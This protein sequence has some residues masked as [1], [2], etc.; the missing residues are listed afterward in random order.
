MVALLLASH[1]DFFARGQHLD[2]VLHA[3]C[4]RNACNGSMVAF[5]ASRSRQDSHQ[6]GRDRYRGQEVGM[7]SSPTYRRCH[8]SWLLQTVKARVP[9]MLLLLVQLADTP[10]KLFAAPSKMYAWK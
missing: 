6:K 2:T 5:L 1:A 3:A 4:R 10:S 8:P 7:G 9:C